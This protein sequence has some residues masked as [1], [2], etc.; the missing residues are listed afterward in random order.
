[1]G[2]GAGSVTVGYRYYMTMQMGLG[3]GPVDE[4][5]EIKVGDKTA[6]PV[7]EGETAFYDTTATEDRLTSIDAPNLFGGDRSEGGIQGSLTIAMGLPIQIYPT[8]FKNLLG[9][10]VPDFRGVVTMIFDGLVCSLNPYPK[11][12]TF[13]LRRLTK[14]WDGPVWHPELVAIPL[15]SSTGTM[16]KGMNP[17]HILYECT[18]NRDWGRGYDR[19]RINDADWLAVA[20][21]LYNE[22]F[23]LCM[24]WNRKSGELQDFVGDVLRHIGG[25]IYTDRQTGLLELK[26]LR[27]DYVVS[28]LPLFTKNSGLLSVEAPEYGSMAK[29]VGEVIVKY[30]EVIVNEDRE[31]RAQNLGVIQSSQGVN[32]SPVTYSGI[33]VFGLAAAVA[34]R[35]LKAAS[36][37]N[38][39]FTVR[40]D[41]R[42]SR[43]YPYAA[44]RISDPDSGIEHAILRAGKID[45]GKLEDGVITVEAV[46]DVFGLPSTSFIE[47]E[48]SAW[49]KP[50]AA[51]APAS[52]V[53]VREGTYQELVQSMSRAELDYV[54]PDDGAIAIFAGRPTPMCLGYD[55]LSKAGT[56]A[57]VQSGG[58]TFAPTCRLAGAIGHYD[59][60]VAFDG[61]LDGGLIEIGTLVQIDDELARVDDIEVNADG[62]SGSM[63]ISRGCI[64]TVPSS[65]ADNTSC[66]FTYNSL[67]NDRRE[68]VT[69]ETVTTKILPLTSAAVLDASLA[70]EQAV[71]MAQRQFRPY[72]PGRV[73]VL[74]GS[75]LNTP[76]YDGASV[77]GN[78]EI[79]WTH[80][81]RIVQD[82]QIISH[83]DGDVTPE[84][85]VTYT[86][87]FFD[88]DDNLIVQYTGITGNSRVFTGVY[89]SL[90]GDMTVRL[91][92]YRN[93]V[94]ALFK[95]EFPL[96]RSF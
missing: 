91:F 37:Q 65:H 10:D 80:R 90:V 33:P 12:W 20:Q 76:A 92:A 13:R 11:K 16:I 58:G 87:Q 29:A 40:L 3:R 51:P 1:M 74:H 54:E 72:P 89:S 4:I 77:V 63:T 93:T 56:E 7:R 55:I 68:Y 78:F 27:N 52:R 38:A 73:R 26:L 66:F 18:T 62:A 28:E 86:L 79:S 42:A 53:Y 60:D 47:Q 23:G 96:T 31:V 6:W 44:F 49:Q 69:G 8:W 64:D 30:R 41:R 59:T 45:Y 21:T 15:V 22:G 19:N 5:L 85:G 46:L 43:I 35:D 36:T 81:N 57:Y 84:D 25:T 61:L 82:D 24:K 88:S 70:S 48:P 32:S 94:S 2:K 95:H 75:S 39:K 14:G 67:G 34:Q 83:E 50:D 17:A 71:T 9:G